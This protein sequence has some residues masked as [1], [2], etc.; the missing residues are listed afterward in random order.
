MEVDL[1]G[2]RDTTVKEVR[3]QVSGGHDATAS[4]L[5]EREL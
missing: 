5:C 3:P 2:S 1:G 4:F